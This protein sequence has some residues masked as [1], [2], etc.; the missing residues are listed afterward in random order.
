MMSYPHA[1]SSASRLTDAL[2]CLRALASHVEWEDGTRPMIDRDGF[3]ATWDRVEQL[4]EHS[5]DAVEEIDLQPITVSRLF[6]ALQN[7]LRTT[8]GLDLDRPLTDIERES[9]TRELAVG[10]LAAVGQLFDPMATMCL[11]TGDLG[12]WRRRRAMDALIRAIQ[13]ALLHGVTEDLI[14]VELELDAAQ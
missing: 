5:P 3:A 1:R 13:L 14:A 11:Q 8:N 4:L 9:W 6:S 10:A 12:R 7:Q 2:D